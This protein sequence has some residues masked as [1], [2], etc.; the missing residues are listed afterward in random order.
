[1]ALERQLRIYRDHR[2][3]YTNNQISRKITLRRVKNWVSNSDIIDK[4]HPFLYTPYTILLP[5][6]QFMFCHFQ[7]KS[8]FY[9]YFQKIY[10]VLN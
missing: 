2:T 5:W 6:N 9:S 1:M 8:I 7:V 3:L 4:K 10:G